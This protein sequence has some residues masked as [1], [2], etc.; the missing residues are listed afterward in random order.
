MKN[1]EE[2][3]QFSKP[4]HNVEDLDE[5]TQS[6]KKFHY[7]CHR[8]T[9]LLTAL[10]LSIEQLLNDFNPNVRNFRRD[11][12]LQPQ[13]FMA[14]K[15][16][17]DKVFQSL[18]VWLQSPVFIDAH[19]PPEIRITFLQVLYLL[20]SAKDAYSKLK[21]ETLNNFITDMIAQIATRAAEE[22]KATEAEA[23]QESTDEKLAYIMLEDSMML[24][25]VQ[26][27]L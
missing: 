23:A 10:L 16:I 27:L 20:V 24:M 6:Q 11:E 15:K 26:K 13:A 22:S 12:H 19:I 3:S 14:L 1:S 17:D 21:G 2:V 7:V 5:I 25:T 4:I 8:A 9:L 18:K